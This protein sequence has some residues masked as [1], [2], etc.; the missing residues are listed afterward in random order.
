MPK[1]RNGTGEDLQRPEHLQEIADA[2]LRPPIET[3]RS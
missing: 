1:H 2:T 3:P